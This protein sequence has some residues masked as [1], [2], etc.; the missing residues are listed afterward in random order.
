MLFL[1]MLILLY[2]GVSCSRITNCELSK[3]PCDIDNRKNAGVIKN[4]EG[5]IGKTKHV[6]TII[7]NNNKTLVPCNIPDSF[8]IEGR[9]IIVSG[10]K[11]QTYPHEKLIGLPFKICNIKYKN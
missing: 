5:K 7:L 3:V 4:V 2:S 6:F 8:K 10:Y 11:K 1:L 9:S